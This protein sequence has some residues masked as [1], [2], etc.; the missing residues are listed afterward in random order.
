MDF[1]PNL[2]D[3]KIQQIQLY[4]SRADGQSFEVPVADLRFTED[5]GSGPVGGGALTVDGLV[6]TRQGNGGAWAAMI[7][8]SPFGTWELSL[9]NQQDVRDLF[10]QDAIQDVLFVVTYSGRTPAWPN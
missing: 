10:D 7:G 1:L 8:R 5:G 3:L 9:P 2:G 4:F 6:S